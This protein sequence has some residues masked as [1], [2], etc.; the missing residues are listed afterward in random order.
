M[1][2]DPGHPGN[3]QSPVRD[4]AS[5]PGFILFAIGLMGMVALA[6][7]LLLWHPEGLIP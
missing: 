3:N 1:F 5:R 6:I 2:G 4:R 7:V